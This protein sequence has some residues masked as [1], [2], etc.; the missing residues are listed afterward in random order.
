[1]CIEK[2]RSKEEKDTKSR[3]A[4]LIKRNIF[5]WFPFQNFF[6]AIGIDHL[7]VVLK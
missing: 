5:N 3:V 6:N 7:Q 1:M 4:Y 2:E